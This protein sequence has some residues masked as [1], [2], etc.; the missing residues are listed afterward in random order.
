M[1]SS[2]LSAH[3]PIISTGSDWAV[4]AQIDIDDV[5]G[6]GVRKLG[7]RDNVGM[8]CLI[9]ISVG[10]RRRQFVVR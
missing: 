8:Q 9:S 3:R 4:L 7:V 10:L 6:A 1:I 5:E 2:F